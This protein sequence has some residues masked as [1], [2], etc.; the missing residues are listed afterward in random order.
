[1][2]GSTSCCPFVFSFGDHLAFYCRLSPQVYSLLS[3]GLFLSKSLPSPFQSLF[4]CCLWSNFPWLHGS[5]SRTASC[6]F[7]VFHGLKRKW[8][9]DWSNLGQPNQRWQTAGIKNIVQTQA[10]HRDCQGCQEGRDSTN[11]P[12]PYCLTSQAYSKHPHRTEAEYLLQ[13]TPSHSLSV[14]RQSLSDLQGCFFHCSA[15]YL[16]KCPR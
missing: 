13:I 14:R 10:F 16:G 1:M 2:S 8:S 11:C 5:R 6:A 12:N 15:P 3:L 7:Y 9:T 4:N